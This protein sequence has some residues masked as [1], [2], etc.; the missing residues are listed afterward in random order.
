VRRLISYHDTEVHTG[1]IYRAAGWVPV[2]VKAKKKLWTWG[3]QSRPRPA[4]QSEA[5]KQRW[6]K[7]L[8]A[9]N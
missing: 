1:T 6:E 5:A 9:G 2:V 3:C 8:Y 4:A 7:V